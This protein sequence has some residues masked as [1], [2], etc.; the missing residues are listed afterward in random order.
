MFFSNYGWLKHIFRNN[1]YFSILKETKNCVMFSTNSILCHKTYPQ[2]KQPKHLP[3]SKMYDKFLHFSYSHFINNYKYKDCITNLI[4]LDTRE[5]KPNLE[6]S[7][8]ENQITKS[9]V[10]I[11]LG[12]NWIEAN[13]LNLDS[14]STLLAP[15]MSVPQSLSIM[16]AFHVLLGLKAFEKKMNFFPK[17]KYLWKK[18]LDQ[19]SSAQLV[20]ILFFLCQSNSAL[21]ASFLNNLKRV[22]DELSFEEWVIVCHCFFKL[23]IKMP[24][25]ILDAICELTLKNFDSTDTYCIITILKAMRYAQFWNDTLWDKL[26]SFVFLNAKKFN[27]IEC[28]HFLASFSNIRFYD[29]LAFTAVEKRGVKLISNELN[30]ED[31]NYFEVHGSIRPRIKDIARFLWALSHVNHPCSLSSLTIFVDV[32]NKMSEDFDN[33]PHILVDYL[34]SLSVYGVYPEKI[35]SLVFN[36][37]FVQKCCDLKKAKPLHQL[38]YLSNSVKIEF[39]SY[40]G[41]TIEEN[42]L[43]DLSNFLKRPIFKELN[44]RLGLSSIEEC[45]KDLFKASDE[46][47]KCVSLLNHIKL[48][49]VTIKMSNEKYLLRL[50]NIFDINTIKCLDSPITSV[51]VLDSSV[52]LIGSYQPIGLLATKIRQL[53]MLGVRVICFT[54]EIVK[55]CLQSHSNLEKYVFRE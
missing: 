2:V 29:Q 41:I 9:F 52:C 53:K 49:S 34:V 22:K 5:V 42:Q 18:Q 30:N 51:E 48:A 40:S 36:K 28:A 35:L 39:P 38:Y 32:H 23:K 4:V 15:K 14:K 16:S 46:E 37:S 20:M 33:N 3:P 47:V 25:S 10:K 13:I 8:L 26:A 54:P 43:D 50:P 11:K 1:N 7:E 12:S 44:N 17:L 19:A 21:T 55:D 27:F 45:L 24:N 31:K 6:L